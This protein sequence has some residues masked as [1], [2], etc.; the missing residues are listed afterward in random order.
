MVSCTAGMRHLPGQLVGLGS[1][2][3]SSQNSITKDLTLNPVRQ[4]R[5]F[6]SGD[7]AFFVLSWQKIEIQK[8][9]FRNE[10]SFTLL[11]S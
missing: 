2:D 8:T 10:M 3:M 4:S 7:I 5:A 11:L 9:R 6:T 1:S